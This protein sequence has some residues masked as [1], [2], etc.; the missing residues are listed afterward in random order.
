MGRIALMDFDVAVSAV[1]VV[2]KLNFCDL[3][4]TIAL[5]AAMDMNSLLINRFLPGGA[6]VENAQKLSL[7]ETE[8]VEMLST[9]EEACGDYGIPPL[10][11]TPTPLCLEG[12]RSYKF[13][14][15]EGCMAGKNLHCAI[16]PS[17][18]MKVCNHSPTIL[19]NCL[20]SDPQELYEN[21]EYV[22]GFSELHS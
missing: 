8:L 22:R 10:I 21:S 18:G 9:V 5:S 12:L 1:I 19:G 13:L 6:G 3:R 20:S 4:D 14:L 15:K 7:N 17:G 11:G 16:D 2:N